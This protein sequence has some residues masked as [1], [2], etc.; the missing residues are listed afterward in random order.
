M[1]GRDIVD[2]VRLVLDDA[3]ATG[4]T[5]VE[6]A[7]W[8][9]DACLFVALL[10]PDAC[11]VNANMTLATGTR[12]S[13]AALAAP[14]LRLLDVVYNVTTG[15]AMRMVDRRRLDAT[16]PTWH[17]ATP[18]DP[19][20]YTFDNRDP[21]TFYVY[22]PAASAKQLNVVYS[23]VPVKITE[24]DLDSV[25]LTPADVYL[26]AI[27][28]YVLFRAKSK[29]VEHAADQA[30]AAGYRALAAELLGFKGSIDK[31]FS[32]V[33]NTPGATPTPAGM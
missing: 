18:G 19:T 29:E 4:W 13:I 26:D 32:P 17:A 33:Q 10:R 2:R 25:D 27:V 9:N 1:K 5:N 23:R 31:L 3:S 14:G 16:L 11:V 6:F 24:A 30:T 8:I 21:A 12:Q 20:D 15:R 22:P 28:N 7:S